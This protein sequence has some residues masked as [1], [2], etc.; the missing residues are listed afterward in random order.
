MTTL[1]GPSTTTRRADR[2]DRSLP[3]ATGVAFA[4]LVVVGNAIYTEG[5]GTTLG[6]S[7]ELLGY[8]ALAVFVSW[9]ALSFDAVHRGATMLAVV[10]GATMIAVKLGGWTAARSSLEESLAPEVAAGLAQVDEVAFVL[11]WLPY[12]LFV[13]GLSLAAGRAGRLPR[14]MAWVGVATG[15]GCVLAVPVSSTE[16]FVLPWL[17]SLL[18]LIAA[19]TLLARGR[20]RGDR[21]WSVEV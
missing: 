9:I 1:T 15:L 5:G 14:P 2:S 16:P 11:G 18:W 4:V 17:F 10:G 12:G 13:I 7:V 6:Y 20:R 19:S 3:A 8:V 21:E